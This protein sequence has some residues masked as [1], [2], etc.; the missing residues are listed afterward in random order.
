M[1]VLGTVVG[2]LLGLALLVGL[3]LVL[4]NVGRA[5]WGLVAPLFVG[6]APVG[7]VAQ[8]TQAPVAVATAATSQPAATAAP[9]TL[10][11]PAQTH[12]GRLEQLDGVFR[13]QGVEAWL[14]A[15]GLT[16]DSLVVEARQIE[17][18]TS[19][20]GRVLASGVQVRATNL[21]VGWPNI[22]TTDTPSRVTTSAETVQHTPDQRNP[23]T[24]YTNVTANGPV[25]VWTSGLSWGQF[26]G[27]LGAGR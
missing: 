10:A 1:R 21:R 15:A 16:W 12:W 3:V 4:W 22:V 20:A 2:A 7:Q 23:S 6:G 5:G 27:R 19:P 11:Q 17:E 9:A 26:T 8:A 25:T 24:L 18:E 14:R 13:V